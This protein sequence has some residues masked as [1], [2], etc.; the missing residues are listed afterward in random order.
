MGWVVSTTATNIDCFFFETHKNAY[1]HTHAL[2]SMNG[3]THIL[4]T[5]APPKTDR[6]ILRFTKSPRTPRP[7]DGYATQAIDCVLTLLVP[8]NLISHP[9][10]IRTHRSCCFF[11][12][13]IVLFVWWA[14]TRNEPERSI[15]WNHVKANFYLLKKFRSV[16]VVPPDHIP[17]LKIKKIKKNLI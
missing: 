11:F 13:K 14:W 1:T 10:E 5:W 12:S 8:K 3:C 4:L 7:I 17:T 16:L 15:D 9:V 2:I 6:Y